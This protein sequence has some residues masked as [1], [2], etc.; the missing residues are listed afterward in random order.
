MPL[1]DVPVLLPTSSTF[2]QMSS[3]TTA[4]SASM[5]ALVIDILDL[6]ILLP[7]LTDRLPAL[8]GLTYL[9]TVHTEMD[10]DPYISYNSLN[11]CFGV[12]PSLVWHFNVAL[13]NKQVKLAKEKSWTVV[14]CFKI[15]L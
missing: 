4:F 14:K 15:Y 11:I 12:I 13:W 10:L 6:L 5:F 7:L 2:I 8:K 9:N 1:F 3:C